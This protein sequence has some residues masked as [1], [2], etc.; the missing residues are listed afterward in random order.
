L[1]G[2]QIR[3]RRLTIPCCREC[4]TRHLH[5]IEEEVS[6]A[7]LDG[8]KAVARIEPLTLFLWLGKI[9]YGLL[10][11]EL[12]LTRE[13]NSGGKGPIVSRAQL[14]AF[15]L[16]HLFLQAARLPFKFLPAVP[17]SMFVFKISPPH[18]IRL[19]WDFRDSLRHMTVSCRVGE[20]GILA[21]LQDGGAQRD[22]KETFWKRYQ[23]FTLAP[24]HF[25]ELSSAFFYSSSLVNRV[26]KFLIIE[27]QGIV[28]VVQNPLQG[29]S[30]KPIFDPWDQEQFARLLSRM[31]GLPFE[32]VFVPPTGV[33]SWLHDAKGRI[34]PHPIDGLETGRFDQMKQPVTSAA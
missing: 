34:Q 21:A 17:A 10:Y 18:D 11:K 29:F 26:P 19:R 32:K 16:H 25:T 27:A 30:L 3:Y 22:S 23:K 20:V 14:R 4:N 6:R 13:R 8:P 9:F 2:T 24:L 31:I 1:N 15:A 28:N 33:A 5:A 12:F 7:T